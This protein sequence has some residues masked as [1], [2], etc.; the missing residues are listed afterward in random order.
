MAP[1]HRKNAD[2]AEILALLAR[3]PGDNAQILALAQASGLGWT[4]VKLG[5]RKGLEALPNVRR[6]GSL[7]SYDGETQSALR[8]AKPAVVIAAGKRSA[9]AALWLKS[10]TGARLVHLGRT[11]SPGEWFDHVVTTPQYRQPR[12]P[13]TVENR[14]PLTLALGRSAIE[15]L[16]EI[17]A[18][19]RPHIF[20]IAGGDAGRLRLDADAAREFVAAAL[21][22]A[23]PRSG[24]LLVATSPRTSPAAVAAIR[25][26]LGAV[27]TPWR[28][29]VFGEGLNHYRAYLAAADELVV[30]DDS[31]SMAAEA[32]AT[33]RRVF[34]FELPARGR[35]WSSALGALAERPGPL[36]AAATRLVE[37]GLVASDRDHRGYME[38]LVADG[39]LAGGATA[40]ALMAAELALAA[41]VVRSLAGAAT[42]RDGARTPIAAARTV[43]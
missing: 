41:E 40:P 24:S 19:P 25:A 13:N 17:E 31:V 8:R 3:R 30:T 2:L 5:L 32:C 16:A 39:L 22:R 34:L 20:A 26:S 36:R 6:G 18:L 12:G 29:T 35:D 27:A 28:L 43:G 21:A 7:F 11:W 10:T 4:S 9:P 33:G 42:G 14:F 15:G 37:L 23:E 38:G 1:T